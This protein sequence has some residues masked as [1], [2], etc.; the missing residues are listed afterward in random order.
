MTR[1]DGKS[2]VYIMGIGDGFEYQLRKGDFPFSSRVKNLIITLL[3]LEGLD[4]D[5]NHPVPQDIWGYLR[6]FG[7]KPNKF[8]E[9][10]IWNGGEE[11]DSSELEVLSR[12]L[13]IKK[14]ERIKE[15]IKGLEER[16]ERMRT[17]QD[18]MCCI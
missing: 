5:I 1:M 3:N 18:Y 10:V 6:S 16:A 4:Y 12:Y 17:E 14:A 15:V 9:V 13:R 2:T 8:Y 11:E 7:Y